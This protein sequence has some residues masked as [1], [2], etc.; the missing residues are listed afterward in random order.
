MNGLSNRFS[1]PMMDETLRLM[2]DRQEAAASLNNKLQKEMNDHKLATSYQDF[3]VRYLRALGLLRPVAYEESADAADNFL[4]DLRRQE[5]K[6]K[7][8]YDQLKAAWL[9][10]DSVAIDKPDVLSAE[11][12]RI[13]AE[14]DEIEE[15]I[16]AEWEDFAEEVIHRAEEGGSGNE[17]EIVQWRVELKELKKDLEHLKLRKEERHEMRKQ[18]EV[19]RIAELIKARTKSL[20]MTDHSADDNAPQ[21]SS[22]KGRAVSR[23][24]SR[25]KDPSSSSSSSRSRSKSSSRSRSKDPSH[26]SRD[27]KGG[28]REKR[29]LQVSENTEEKLLEEVFPPHI[30]RALR[31]GR[32]VEPESKECVTIFFSDIVG[33]TN[34]SSSISPLKVSDMLDRLY[35]KFDKLSHD[36]DVV[37]VCSS[38]GEAI[39]A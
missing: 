25:T 4:K 12:Q 14:L 20:S 21:R 34:I 1:S 22:S 32:K 33:F 17:S 35:Q 10:F 28:K 26:R 36:H 37:R 18:A 39:D 15:E 2:K 31:E 3:R 38:R 24:R 5:K 13:E 29:K 19:R 6:K 27:R 7:V 9:F 16:H 11:D 8:R 30:A 23:S